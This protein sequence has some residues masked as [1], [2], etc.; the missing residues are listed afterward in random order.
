MKPRYVI[1]AFCALIFC[2]PFTSPLIRNTTVIVISFSNNKLN[3]HR[4]TVRS[5]FYYLPL[6]YR[7]SDDDGSILLIYWF[8]Q[9]FL[10]SSPIKKSTHRLYRMHSILSLPSQ[11]VTTNK[12]W[13]FQSKRQRGFRK[14][15]AL[16]LFVTIVQ[17][18][19]GWNK[20]QP[21]CLSYI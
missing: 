20:T 17:I 1:Q 7:I 12:S 18:H 4:Q 2:I 8:Q 14:P 6:G 13:T 19:C 21:Q 3:L 5:E 10:F 9:G 15:R 11:L 16:P